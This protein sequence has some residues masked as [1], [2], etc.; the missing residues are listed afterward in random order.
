MTRHHRLLLLA[1]ILAFITVIILGLVIS[2][3]LYK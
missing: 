2:K 1:T 3:G